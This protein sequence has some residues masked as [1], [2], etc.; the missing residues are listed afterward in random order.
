[1][2]EQRTARRAA[3][4]D[5]EHRG[6]DAVW[7]PWIENE[8][9]NAGVRKIEYIVGDQPLIEHAVR[10]EMAKA[11]SWFIHAAN[12][13]YR[14]CEPMEGVFTAA[15]EPMTARS[16]KTSDH[17]FSGASGELEQAAENAFAAD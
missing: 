16:I 3:R 13:V 10:A 14:L 12:D 17:L 2:I 9:T 7:K 15:P 8:S 1:M 5:K 4:L 11:E 6:L